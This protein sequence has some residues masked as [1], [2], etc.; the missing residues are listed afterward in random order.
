MKKRITIVISLMIAAVMLFGSI[1]AYAVYVDGDSVMG[2]TAYST[3]VHQMAEGLTFNQFY[4][5]TGST[6]QSC[7]TMEYNPKTTPFRSYIYHTKVS[8]GY[9]VSDD[10]ASAA[11]KGMKVYGAVN[12]DFFSMNSANYGTPDNMFCSEGK[13]KSSTVTTGTDFKLYFSADGSAHVAQSK[14]KYTLTIG[15]TDYS[16]SF[17]YVNKRPKSLENKFY[18]FDNDVYSST[19]ALSNCKYIMCTYNSG[20]IGIGKT[21]TGTVSAITTSGNSALTGKNF[22]LLCG[23]GLGTSNIKVGNTVTINVQETLAESKAGLESAQHVITARFVLIHNGVDR[24]KNGNGE[25]PYVDAMTNIVAHRTVFGLKPDGTIVYFVCDGWNSSQWN[26][27]TFTNIVSMMQ[28]LG[29]TEVVNLDGDGSSN[30][31][32]SEGNGAFNHE[33]IGETPERTDGNSILIIR[34][35]NAAPEPEKT[36]DPMPG[37]FGKDLKNVAQGASYSLEYNGTFASPTYVSGYDDS[38]HKKLTD[39]NYRPNVTSS[40][41]FGL[42]CRTDH[43]ITKVSQRYYSVR[44]PRIQRKELHRIRIER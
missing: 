43:L 1:P 5:K 30:C 29:C 2:S 33:Y 34:D 40:V 37:T 36:Y 20:E 3:E 22:V 27:L 16:S 10:A 26:G 44:Q 9:R 38:S 31:I 6:R 28:G 19:P 21:I 11:A 13:L 4:Y 23:S 14:L 25:I 42:Q 8:Y 18:Y 24:W 39:G 17:G 35:P 7:Y 15:G 41:S 32:I 12:G